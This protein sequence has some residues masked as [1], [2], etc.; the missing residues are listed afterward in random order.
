VAAARRSP[1]R[2]RRR[3]VRRANR[4]PEQA[5]WTFP[6]TGFVSHSAFRQFDRARRGKGQAVLSC[7]TSYEQ[8]DDRMTPSDD[9]LFSMLVRRGMSR[10]AFIRFCAAITG[11]LALPATY[12]PRVAA[13]LGS[14]DARLIARGAA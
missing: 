13:A 5:F 8:G 7:V 1:R 9:G 12:A 4:P 6:N 11:A 2:T 14:S 3:A 10:R